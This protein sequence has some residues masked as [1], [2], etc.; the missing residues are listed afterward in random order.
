MKVKSALAD[1]QVKSGGPLGQARATF[2]RFNVIDRDGDWTLPGAFQDGIQIPVSAYGHESWKGALPVGKATIHSDREKAWA[3]VQFLMTTQAGRDTFEVVRDLGELGE[4][5]YGWEPVSVSRGK[6][7]DGSGETVQFLERV[8]IF[9]ISPVLRG[10]G[11]RTT[12]EE[13]KDAVLDEY[14]R[15]VRGLHGID[16]DMSETQRVM[17]LEYLKFVRAAVGADRG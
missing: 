5:S 8:K 14:L 9:E 12:T 1:V 11:I 17:D 2:S 13:T 6:A 4:W 7:P 10:S 3:D 15:Y 16:L